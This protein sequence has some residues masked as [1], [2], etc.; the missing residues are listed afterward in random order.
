MKKHAKFNIFSILSV[1]DKELTHSSVIKLVIEQ[2]VEFLKQFDINEDCIV[3]TEKS[4]KTAKNKSIRFDIIGFN[5]KNTG[6]E[7]INFFI[8]NKFKATPTKSQLVMYDDF[9]KEKNILPKKILMVYFSEQISSDVQKYCN[10]EGWKVYPYFSTDDGESFIKFLA[11]KRDK[12]GPNA[13]IKFLIDEYI[14]Y[15][16]NS[17]KVLSEKIN[18]KN[19]FLRKN[20]QN[21]ELAYDR[22]RDVWFRYLMHIQS[23]IS[24][25]IDS[26][27]SYDSGNDGGSRPIP[28]VVFWFNNGAYFGIDGDSVKLG[29]LYDY[30]NYK[31]IE[32]IQSELNE[33][34]VKKMLVDDIDFKINNSKP[35]EKKGKDGSSVI[36]LISFNL[37]NW[38]EKDIF[39]ETSGKI[40]NNYYNYISN[41]LNA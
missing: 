10:D 37:N 6:V 25:K 14:V 4:F 28:S 39:I 11:S 32:Y 13:K 3:E 18:D 19:L 9:F 33:T 23:L 2:D 36:F 16:S 34:L 17:W 38:S 7:N 27:I 31:A 26:N 21:L 8:E 30:K 12:F 24:T 15:L 20:F 22:D 40:L 41:K 29:V 1:A 35:K 5:N